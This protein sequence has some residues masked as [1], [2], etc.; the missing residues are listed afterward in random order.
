V[1][2]RRGQ[3]LPALRAPQ[4]PERAASLWGRASGKE[5]FE[6]SDVGS[7]QVQTR[8]PARGL[9]RDG[10]LDGDARM[11]CVMHGAAGEVGRRNWWSETRPH[12]LSSFRLASSRIRA[13]GK[14]EAR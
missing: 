13:E 14:P 3:Y 9:A 4:R 11:Q 10:M 2:R 5:V 12:S 6:T 8:A 7:V 1:A